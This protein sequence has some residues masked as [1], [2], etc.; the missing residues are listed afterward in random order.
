MKD[1]MVDTVG[2]SNKQKNAVQGE[3]RFEKFNSVGNNKSLCLIRTRD[4]LISF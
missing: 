2:V 1:I 4:L 3:K